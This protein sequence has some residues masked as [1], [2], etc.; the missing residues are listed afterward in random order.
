[1]VTSATG[2]VTSRLIPALEETLQPLARLRDSA[3]RM[4]PATPGGNPGFETF[5]V[6]ELDRLSAVIRESA[7]AITRRLRD[8]AH[9]E[10][11]AGLRWAELWRAGESGNLREAMPAASVAKQENPAHSRSLAV[12]YR[13]T[14]RALCSALCAARQAADTNS[15]VLLSSVLQRLEKQLWLL[16]SSRERAQVRLPL[17]NLFLSC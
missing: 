1:M 3:D 6:A 5:S 15:T 8:L 11:N 10:E 16:D 9:G 7:A 4:R 14:C 17:I 12:T 13:A 2:T